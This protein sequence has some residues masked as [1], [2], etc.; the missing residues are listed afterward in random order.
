LCLYQIVAWR[1]LLVTMAGR[2]CPDLPCDTVFDTAEWQAVYAVVK[3]TPLPTMPPNL[4]EM[5]ALVARLGGYQGRK[6]DPPPGP[7]AIWIGMQQARTLALAWET[8]GPG[9]K[10][11]A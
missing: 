8:F 1:V 7:Q 11:Y 6:S 3:R 5:V 4:A 2:D 10:T 9:A